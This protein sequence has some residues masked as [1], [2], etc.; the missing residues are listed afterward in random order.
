MQNTYEE[1]KL[2]GLLQDRVQTYFQNKENRKKFEKWYKEKYG[3]P[4]KWR[5]ANED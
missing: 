1:S 3:K 4:Y 2:I 5:K